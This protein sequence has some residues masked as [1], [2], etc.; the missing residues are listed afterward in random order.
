LG[1]ES[2]IPGQGTTF[3]QRLRALVI[4]PRL[5]VRG[6][7]GTHLDFELQAPDFVP[8]DA[9][10]W[11]VALLDGTLPGVKGVLKDLV[12]GPGGRPA[13]LVFAPPAEWGTL[14]RI[15]GPEVDAFA[16]SELEE[17]ELLDR[18]AEA[19]DA[20][21][22]KVGMAE[23]AREG[24]ALAEE[25]A[26]AKARM[27]EDLRLAGD[28]QRS[29]HPPPRR[30]P[31]LDIGRE[32]LPAREIGGDYY[33]FVPAGEKRLLFA[34]GDV[35]GKG[36]PAA[37]LAANLKASLRAQLRPE[38]VPPSEILATV[39]RL[40]CELHPR[41]RFSTLFV[42]VFC[43]EEGRLHYANAGHPP[44]FHVTTGG[45]VRDLEAAGPALGLVE[46]ATFPESAIPLGPEDLLVFFSDGVTD[47]TDC[48][49]NPF[50]LERLKA[51]A[52]AS[53]R[54]PARIALYSILGEVQG[55]SCGAAA[56]DDVTLVLTKVLAP[57]AP[58]NSQA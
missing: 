18:I 25:L 32:F 43:F 9:A 58:S 51:A 11:D 21:E 22:L 13:T 24:L 26:R 38:P 44:P 34:I 19:R 15:L 33:D 3:R 10:L 52:Q 2:R 35:M 57:P 53:R 16:E 45:E 42:S 37:L 55:F 48:N 47:R 20:H 31:R 17:H 49:G 39:N 1:E 7:A 36:V 5:P 54:D 30:H 50:G 23:R 41:G 4:G 28:V 29:L 40:F 14:R 6:M 56:E 8:R 12:G 46:D 27:A